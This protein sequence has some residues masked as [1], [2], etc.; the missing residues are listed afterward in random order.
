MLI[1]GSS[2]GI[3]L[4]TASAPLRPR[5]AA[6]VLSARSAREQLDEA[7]TGLGASHGAAVTS[8]VADVTDPGPSGRSGAGG[9]RGVRR[10]IDILVNNVGGGFGGGARILDSA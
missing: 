5:A 6:L 9:R 1:T 3:G 10:G 4:A 7:A 8:H 2:R